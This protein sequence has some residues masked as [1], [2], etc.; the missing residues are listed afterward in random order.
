MPVTLATQEAEFRKI[1]VRS[2]P[3]QTVPKTLSQKK[4]FT[5]KGWWS[6]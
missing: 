3:G 1:E 5:K 2:Q 4:P 6:D